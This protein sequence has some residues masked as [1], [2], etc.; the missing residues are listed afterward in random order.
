MS[1]GIGTDDDVSM[2][3]ETILYKA[4][5]NDSHRNIL[6]THLSD[7]KK[8]DGSTIRCNTEH[9]LNDFNEIREIPRELLES[10]YKIVDGCAG[11]Y[12]CS[13]VLYFLSQIALSWSV[14]F[15]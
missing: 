1:E 6:Y 3:G 7:D 4:E 13:Q 10:K 14:L 8:Q 11:Q 9:V 12:C 2:E 15:V 5:G